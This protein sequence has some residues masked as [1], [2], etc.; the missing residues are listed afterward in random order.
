[1][2]IALLLLP[3]LAHAAESEAVKTA[4]A[5]V[6]LV[7]DTDS[8]APGEPFRVGLRLRLAPG[9]HTYWK[10]PGDAGVA[11]ELDLTLPPGATATE[12]AWPAPD[13]L[14][15]GPIATYAYTGDLLLSVSLT[16]P[17]APTIVEAQARWLVCKEICVPE[18]GSFRLNLSSG[19]PTPSAQAGLFDVSDRRLPRP[20][21]GRAQIGPDGNLGI[22]TADIGPNTVS[23]AM[24]LPAQ[25]GTIDHGAPQ[26]V[27]IRPGRLGLKLIPGKL[28]QAASPLDGVLTLHDRAGNRADFDV[29]AT[30]GGVS[31]IPPVPLSQI[32]LFAFLGG[33]ILNAMPCVFPILALKAISLVG[34]ASNGRARAHALS[35]TAGIMVAFIALGAVLLG[36]RAGGAAAGWGFQFQS[37]VFVAVMAW[38]LFA[39]GLNLS[40]VFEIGGRSAGAGQNLAARGGQA[41]SFF[42]GLLAVLVATP[43][44]APF[45]GVAIAAALAAPPAVTILVFAAM[46]LGLAAPYL[47]LAFYPPL[48]RL[49]PRPG[50]WMVVFKQGLAFPMYGA[51]IWLL[52][53]MAQEAGPPGVLAAAAGALLIGF[54]AWA[55]N[56]ASPPVPGERP[57]SGRMFAQ[58]AAFAALLGAGAILAGIA[59]APTASDGIAAP[60]AGIE[61]FSRERLVSLRA[62][63][64]PV[65]VNMTAAWCVTCLV[66][67]RLALGSEAVRTAFAKNGITYLKGDWTRQDAAITQFLGDHGRDGV[68]LYVFYPAANAPPVVLPQILTEGNVLAAL[69]G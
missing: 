25:A 33:V 54:A 12:I 50:R 43:C 40:G 9:W 51:A 15:E 41:G 69:R 10:N 39:V 27:T 1:M 56:A 5:T 14:R 38:L 20:L 24:F 21:P 47:L 8:I 7:S 53:V 59:Y 55:W 36:L 57:S 52:W 30:P 17:S 13:P 23:D 61:R 6:T 65:F 16:E 4:R 66:N 2:V 62:E 35:Y 29:H 11:P 45:M 63:G 3:T 37:P 46:G 28:F 26:S 67:E 22:E 31:E 58:A 19:R 64:R 60:E 44:T 32:V 18:Q 42:T 34:A 49:F 68:P 48:A